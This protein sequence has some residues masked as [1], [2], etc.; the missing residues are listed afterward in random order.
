M[1]GLFDGPIRRLSAHIAEGNLNVFCELGPPFA[2][3]AA[4][5]G[6]AAPPTADQI[7][8]FLSGVRAIDGDAEATTRLRAGFGHYCA[9]PSLAD[10][11]AV[12]EHTLLASG[13]IGLTEQIRLQPVIRAALDTPFEDPGAAG[14][15]SNLEAELGSLL[16]GWAGAIPDG[17]SVLSD[18]D[19]HRG[20]LLR[21][22]QAIWRR[23]L[24]RL[25]LTIRMPDQP[26]A[27]SRDVPSPDGGARWPADL[28]R[29]RL[30]DLIAFLDAQDRT[31]GTGMGS[32]AQDWAD[33]DQR[34]NYIVNL[35]RSWQQ[36]AR[37]LTP[38]FSD[39]QIAVM[40][41]GRVPDGPL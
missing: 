34:M 32:G 27:L 1:L 5:L 28:A 8:S 16:T 23:V 25:F 9:V 14:A 11:A 18:L 17:R 33:L 30:A 35:F 4:L 15:G 6:G 29:L 10:P 21:E 12:A 36:H 3:L 22:L 37:L 24:T 2:A 31:G 39:A 13:L 7:D 19:R 38:P 41:S 26:L 20:E 40:Q